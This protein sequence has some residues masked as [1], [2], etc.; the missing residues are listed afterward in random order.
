M[1]YGMVYIKAD[2]HAYTSKKTGNTVF[3]MGRG[4][5]YWLCYYCSK[6]RASDFNCDCIPKSMLYCWKC[7]SF[8]CIHE[9]QLLRDW[10]LKRPPVVKRGL[11][12]ITAI[13]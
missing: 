1:N 5:A 2:W 7:N 12:K 11:N 9:E 3:E 10:F 13:R 8:E 4:P 6:S